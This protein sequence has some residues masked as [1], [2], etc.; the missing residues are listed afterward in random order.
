MEC[1]NASS[2]RH[3]QGVLQTGGIGLVTYATTDIWNYSTYSFAVNEIYSESHGYVMR[4]LDENMTEHDQ[5]DSRWN[6]V[7]ALRRL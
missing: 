3:Q 6:K 5:Y 4:H 1:T 2:Y 7:K